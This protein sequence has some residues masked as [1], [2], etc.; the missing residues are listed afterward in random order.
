MPHLG[1][2]GVGALEGLPAG[3]ST[4]RGI[5]FRFASR[6][7]R[8]RFLR[9]D[10]PVT[11]ALPHPASHV[12][13]AHFCQAHR[14]GSPFTRP[15]D[16]EPDFLE[17]VGE[18]V[19]TVRV[20]SGAV[21][22]CRQPIRL[23]IEVEQVHS[24]LEPVPFSAVSDRDYMRVDWRGP[25]EAQSPAKFGEPG[26]S[27]NAALPGQWGLNQ[28]GAVPQPASTARLWLLPIPVVLPDDGSAWM[29]I[30]PSPQPGAPILYVAG[31]TSFRGVSDPFEFRPRQTLRITGDHAADAA[32]SVDLGVVGHRQK[33]LAAP[34]AEWASSQFIGW[35][36]HPDPLTDRG[37][38]VDVSAAEDA[39]LV[40]NHIP[41]PMDRIY[42]AGV[43][44]SASMRIEVLPPADLPLRVTIT[45]ADTGQPTPAR[46][47]FRTADGRYLPPFG[48]RRE[49]NPGW[50]EDNGSDLLLGGTPYAY[51]PGTFEMHVPVGTVFVEVSKG[52]EYRPVREVF[53][54][55]PNHSRLPIVLDRAHDFRR[56]GWVTA[57]THVHFL[58]PT[59]ALLQA[60]AEGLNLVNVLAAQWG[61]LFTNIVDEFA[62]SM[63]D[64]SSEAE[65]RVGSENRMHVLGH[66]SLIGPGARVYPLGTGGGITSPLGDP[67]HALIAD[68]A[69]R[70]R[71][72]GGVSIAAHFPFPYG[73]VAA[74][75]VLDKLDAVELFG[76]APRPD[77]PRTRSWY[78][79]LNAGFRIP[80]VGG[81]DKMSAGTAVGA[82]RTYARLPEDQPYSFEA[83]V[84]AVRSG[85]TFLTS[86]PLL[87]I[88]VEGRGPGEVIVSATR[89][90]R[91]SARV[92]AVSVNPIDLLQLVVNGSVVAESKPGADG[93]SAMIDT[94][95]RL[96][97]SAW[98]AARCTSPDVIYTAYPTSVGAHT[99]PVYVECASRPL[100]QRDDLIAIAQLIEAGKEWA[101]RRAIV[102]SRLD[103][104]RFV[105]FFEAASRRVRDRLS[106]VTADA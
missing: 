83:W 53:N 15:G 95:L 51:V 54:I 21:E 13:L 103:R 63:S 8:R 68:L 56:S 99:S 20:G 1:Q 9:I 75:I 39:T 100:A 70:T 69:D 90:I 82:V 76:F 7:A 4:V 89:D 36:D 3:R 5:P 12:L 81:T 87:E 34:S 46:V 91:L 71:A 43:V 29:N 40:V 94:S 104:D 50:M 86:G 72:A 47:H 65:I 49:V 26:S 33:P 77:G 37:L 64:R 62:G 45:A 23:G 24:S 58:S 92:R 55:T 78:R 73:E 98:I 38:L 27:S 67:F 74:D 44:E 28:T 60:R 97:G 106:N 19:A 10:D 93:R 41:W 6:A 2:G 80:V 61:E 48:H 105:A 59:S 32:I 79:F 16:P 96:D 102:P 52:F 30:E 17:R 31:V 22:I 66:V 101:A 14:D 42:R 84:E 85:R 25:H 35:G 57:D 18:L 88:D 11:I